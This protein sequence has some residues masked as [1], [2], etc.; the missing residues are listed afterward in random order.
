M[1]LSLSEADL[2][3]ALHILIGMAGYLLR[4]LLQFPSNLNVDTSHPRSC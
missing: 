4:L 1:A 3:L 2:V